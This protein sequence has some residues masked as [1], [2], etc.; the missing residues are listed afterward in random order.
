[1]TCVT[2]TTLEVT[3]SALRR[4]LARWPTGVAVITALGYTGPVGKTVNS[5]HATSLEPGLVGWCV[6]HRSSQLADW[7]ATEGYV[8]HVVA[9]DQADL[10]TRFATSSSDR[11]DGLDWTPGLDGM[12]LLPIEV[13][14]RLECRVTA[15]FPVGDHTYLIGEV[16]A[17]TASAD[18]VPMT[19]R[20]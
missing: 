9:D 6:D 2:P 16:V 3:P 19:L 18:A 4:Q 14:L 8:V 20:R 10:I 17:M 13:P 5:F 15:R 7:L 11:F 1:M 12:P